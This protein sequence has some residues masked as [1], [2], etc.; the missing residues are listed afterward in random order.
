[1]TNQITIQ[2]VESAR[3][4]VQKYLVKTPLLYS[5]EFSEATGNEVFFKLEN[6]QRTHAFKARGALN[7]V[8]SLVKAERERGVIAA[9]SGNHALGVAFASALL[10]IQALVVMPSRAPKP[11]IDQAKKYGAQVLLHGETYDDALAHARVL[12]E[13][14]GKALL[15]SFDD[16]KVIAGQGTIALEVLEEL[17]DLDL[18][19]APIGGGGLVSGLGVTL[20]ALGHSAQVIGVE[21]EG[22]QS[23]LESVRAGRSLKLDK[24]HTIA[25]GIAVQQP[26]MLNFE[27]VKRFVKEIF[28]VSDEQILDGMFRMLQ[29]VRVVVEPAA[30]A[31][32]AVL[33]YEQK[34][35]NLGKKICCVITGG[36]IAHSLLQQVAN[37]QTTS[38]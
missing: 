28:T 16:L 26:G 19:I 21:A 13:E 31:A 25:D 20:S 38:P 7:K 23:M 24:I 33:L 9:S 12:A 32:P 27:Y 14:Q 2:D 10:G 11:K 3:L 36:N 30:A 8:N 1:M 4:L 5:P 18:F 29:D 6:L 35:Q 17:P 15:P 34:L 22:C 37:R